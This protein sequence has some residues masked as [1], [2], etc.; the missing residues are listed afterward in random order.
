MKDAAAD[1]ICGGLAGALATVPMTALMVAGQRHLRWLK[2]ETLPP[3]QITESLLMTVGLHDDLRPSQKTRLAFINH[4]G[5]GAAMGAFY[6]LAVGSR[7]YR[8]IICGA[9]YGLGVWAASYLGAMPALRL[10]RSPGRDSPE[11]NL[12][13][14]GAHLVW[15]A[16]LGLLM[17]FPRAPQS[18]G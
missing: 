17:Q 3:R 14:I 4:F 1:G 2:R 10:Y 18:R 8:P 5:Y 13:M 12:L 15:G 11:R 9:A 16:A 7:R 6:G